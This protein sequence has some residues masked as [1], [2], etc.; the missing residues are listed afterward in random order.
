M[1]QLRITWQ[2]H[3]RRMWDLFRALGRGWTVEQIHELTKK[4]TLVPAAVH[5]DRRDARRRGGERFDGLGADDLRR[6]KRAGSA[7]GDRDW[8]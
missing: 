5:R 7:S 1:Q 2:F 8:R 6:L 4:S 3:D